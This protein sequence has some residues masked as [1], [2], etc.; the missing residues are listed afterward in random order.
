[1]AP[2]GFTPRAVGGEARGDVIDDRAGDR[3]AVLAAD[4]GQDAQ[5]VFGHGANLSGTSGKV[6]SDAGKCK[7]TNAEPGAMQFTL[8]NLQPADQRQSQP[9]FDPG[10]MTGADRVGF[11]PLHAA[12]ASPSQT[13]PRRKLAERE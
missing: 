9:V 8:A 2:G 13:S 1:M 5:F 12:S 4:H 11:S 3:G 7:R 10:R 6:E